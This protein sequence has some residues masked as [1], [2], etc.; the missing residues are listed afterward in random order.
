MQACI[1]KFQ[2][3]FAPFI[4][5]QGTIPTRNLLENPYVLGYGQGIIS[6]FINRYEIEDSY[7]QGRIAMA[8]L[9]EFLG[10]TMKEI[11]DRLL[12]LHHSE[13]D[14]YLKGIQDGG[15]RITPLSDGKLEEVTYR[16]DNRMERNPPSEVH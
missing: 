12:F 5:P 7:E 8:V 3:I 4:P 1:K 16:L 9:S 13:N 10:C 14:E 11:S 6:V 2:T 15:D